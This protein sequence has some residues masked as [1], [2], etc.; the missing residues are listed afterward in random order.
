MMRYCDLRDYGKLHEYVSKKKPDFA[1]SFKAE[2]DLRIQKEDHYSVIER[3]VFIC[4]R[5]L[6][7][8]IAEKLLKTIEEDGQTCWIST[9]NLRPD[10]SINYWT[11]IEEAINH[12][13]VFLVVS[14]REAMLSKDVQKELTIAN[15]LKKEKIEYKIDDSVHTTLFKRSF[16]GEKWI[17]AIKKANLDVLNDRLFDKLE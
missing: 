7:H 11:N 9:R 8:E 16:D 17:D 13:K 6:D 15:K 2:F 3:D 5:S 1:P 10:D 14:S 4:H 12:C